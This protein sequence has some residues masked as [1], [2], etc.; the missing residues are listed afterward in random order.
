[1]KFLKGLFLVVFF[2]ALFAAAG[3]GG[4]YAIKEQ[5]KAE[6]EI[7]QPKVEQLGT[8]F[9][10]FEMYQLL[11]GHNKEQ[12]KDTAAFVYH[13]FKLQVNTYDNVANFWLNSDFYKQ[14]QTGIEEKDNAFLQDLIANTTFVEGNSD[15]HIPD[16]I[17]VTLD[18]PKQAAQQL[19]NFVKYT[20]YVT[21][22][23]LYNELIAKWKTLFNQ[24]NLAAQQ[25]TDNAAQN[26][27]SWKGK[28]NMMKSVSPLDN[29]LMTFDYLKSPSQPRV[30]SPDRL[31]WASV[32]GAIG[33]LLG[34]LLAL[35]FARRK[36]KNHS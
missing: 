20:N 1:M 19:D 15:R 17:S 4:S 18:N 26:E 7:G 10:L 5:W 24:V 9:S 36:Q 13:G 33:F 22:Q 2:T 27:L 21:Q 35:I 16:R 25:S 28:L 12:K 34:L 23:S 14:R 31:L 6:A 3:Y 11:N 30:A 32:G 29:Q 8:Y